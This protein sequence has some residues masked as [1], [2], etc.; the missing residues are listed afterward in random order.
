[1]HNTEY[2]H[3]IP[4]ISSSKILNQ[5]RRNLVLPS[6]YHKNRLENARF[7]VFHSGAVKKLALT[8]ISFC[9][10]GRVDPDVSKTMPSLETF[11]VICLKTRPRVPKEF[12]LKNSLN[13]VSNIQDSGNITRRRLANNYRCFVRLFCISL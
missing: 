10:A 7:E 6:I 3:A 8:G 2:A 9:V 11:V 13:L 1:M 5:F 12:I 4:S